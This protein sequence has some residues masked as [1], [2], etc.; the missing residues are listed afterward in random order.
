MKQTSLQMSFTRSTQMHVSVQLAANTMHGCSKGPI[1][2][3]ATPGK[4]AQ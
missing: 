1:M 4:A 3:A 2:A